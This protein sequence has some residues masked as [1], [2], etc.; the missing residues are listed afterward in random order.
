MEWHRLRQRDRL[1]R[2]QLARSGRKRKKTNAILSQANVCWQMSFPRLSLGVWPGLKKDAMRSD[3][4]EVRHVY[5]ERA[6]GQS[7]MRKWSY[8][9]E[10]CAREIA[11][12]PAPVTPLALFI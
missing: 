11:P 9:C 1:V 4:E 8:V 6:L 5:P 2:S 12:I 10:I 7:G 3:A